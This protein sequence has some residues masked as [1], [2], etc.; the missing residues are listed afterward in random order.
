MNTK[1]TPHYTFIEL[2]S[3]PLCARDKRN[4]LWFSLVGYSKVRSIHFAA[5]HH[6]K[7]VGRKREKTSGLP[8]VAKLYVFGWAWVWAWV[9]LVSER[10]NRSTWLRL[11][12]IHS[13]FI[14]STPL[15]SADNIYPVCRGSQRVELICNYFNFGKKNREL[16]PLK[17]FLSCN[18][19]KVL[20]VSIHYCTL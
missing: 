20:R 13:P 5:N 11:S 17:F 15:Y 3:A 19:K 14:K 10:T 8:E 6:D 9:Y 12:A 7:S 16:F 18:P 2:D 4:Y 1:K